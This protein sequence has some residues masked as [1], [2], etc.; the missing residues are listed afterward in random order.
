MR[1]IT[2]SPWAPGPI[3]SSTFKPGDAALFEL[4]PHYH[5]PNRPFFD[6]VELKGGGDAASAARAVLQTGEYDFAWNLQVEKEVLERM[7]R[8][9]GRGKIHIYP[10]S[11]VE[12]IQLNRTDPET[13]IEGERSSLEAPHPFLT[14]PMVRQAYSLL[15]DRQTIAQQL[16]GAAG[17][18]TSNFLNTPQR[19]QS[20]HTRWEFNPQRPRNCSTRPAGDAA[21]MDTGRKMDGA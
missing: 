13:E 10:G 9:G 5:V 3:R 1:P 19:F 4:N 16:Y 12:H 8:Q 15:M 6:G 2:S 18:A 11:G 17:Q 14:D 20:P 7:E 21:A